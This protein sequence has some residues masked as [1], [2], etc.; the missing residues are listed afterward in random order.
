[1]DLDDSG[2]LHCARVEAVWK[3]TSR[4]MPRSFPGSYFP[5]SQPYGRTPA[6]PPP[7][8]PS[9]ER[10]KLARF[11]CDLAWPADATCNLQPATCNLQWTWLERVIGGLVFIRPASSVA[12][13]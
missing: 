1:M 9:F 7:A 12:P 2:R 10:E 8:S 11:G 4:R 13:A 6:R 5:G 3:P